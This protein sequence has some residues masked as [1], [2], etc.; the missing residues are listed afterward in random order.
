MLCFVFCRHGFTRHF[1]SPVLAGVLQVSFTFT[2]TG[3]SSLIAPTLGRLML[4]SAHQPDLRAPLI[5]AR[6]EAAFG[7]VSS[8]FP[9]GF[10]PVAASRH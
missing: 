4:P 10:P 3:H 8:S 1:R 9:E 7:R 6:R 2:S 5:S